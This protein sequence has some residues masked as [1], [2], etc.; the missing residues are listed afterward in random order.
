MVP[1]APELTARKSPFWWGKRVASLLG[2]VM[3][4]ALQLAAVTSNW[5]SVLVEGHVYFVDADCYSR[6][7]RVLSILDAGPWSI[8]EHAFENWPHGT[9][10][11]TTAPLDFG[12]LGVFHAL[13]LFGIDGDS[14]LDLAGAWISPI[15]GVVLIVGLWAW[16]GWMRLPFRWITLIVI[17]V[18]PVVVQAMKFGRPDHQSLLM[19]LIA[20]GVAAEITLW[21]RP[22]RVAG[23]VWGI[24]WALALWVSFFEPLIVF[25]LLFLIRA[26]CLKRA[27]MSQA[28]MSAWIVFIVGFAVVVAVD[29]WRL[30]GDWDPAIA[31]YFPHWATM[32]GELAPVPIGSMNWFV[33]G[34]FGIVLLPV[35]LGWQ[36]IRMSDKTAILCVVLVL[37]TFCLSVWQVRWASYF[38]LL[39]AM[40]VPFALAGLTARRGWIY[41]AFIFSLWPV[42]AAWETTIFPDEATIARSDE[43][44]SENIQLRTIA[45]RMRSHDVEGFLAP[46]WLSPALAYWSGQP[47]VS[48]SSHQSLGGIVDAARFFLTDDRSAAQGILKERFVTWVVTDDPA[49]IEQ[50]S[51]RLLQE[52]PPTRSLA[53]E[54]SQP[55]SPGNAAAPMPRLIRSMETEFFV[56]YRN[57]KAAS[58]H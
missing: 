16:M 3:V 46:W 27:A 14:A 10:P 47:G 50:T 31:H 21:Q 7:T 23:W 41:L 35:L 2:L 49:R 51:S 37:V 58:A 34:G 33:W 52:A 48:G 43:M 4:I 12:I 9:R 30:G 32:L 44:L 42:A 45:E 36:A 40:S 8:R 38:I 1:G 39:A 15:L 20:A 53:A 29:G 57:Q 22:H 6:M 13:Q 28:W 24:V 17:A 5:E 25:G 26:L 18:S 55:G 54:L 56:L 19:L 11:H